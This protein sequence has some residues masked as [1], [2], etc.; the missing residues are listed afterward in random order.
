M[1]PIVY[2]LEGKDLKFYPITVKELNDR[3]SPYLKSR[4]T[5]Y[6]FFRDELGRDLEYYEKA[7]LTEEG[8]REILSTFFMICP[9]SIYILFYGIY[10][11]L[12]RILYHCLIV[13]SWLSVVYSKSLKVN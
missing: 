9:M 6:K 8:M 13:N 1:E 4:R 11:E 12:T 7:R 5:W 2:T 3:I 10:Q